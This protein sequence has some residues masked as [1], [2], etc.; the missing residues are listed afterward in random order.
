MNAEATDASQ[1][2]EFGNWVI[3]TGEMLQAPYFMCLIGAF[4][5]LVLT[6][7]Q[8]KPILSICRA[9]NIDVGMQAK[10]KIVLLDLMLSAML[11]AFIVLHLAEPETSKQ[12]IAAGL[13][14]AGLLSAAGRVP[15]DGEVNGRGVS[16]SEAAQG[17]AANNG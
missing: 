1:T 15:K 12:S 16:G 7:S 9:I 2:G 11:G 3:W 10:P 6:R 8:E 5:L 17:E 4:A 14:M 13:G